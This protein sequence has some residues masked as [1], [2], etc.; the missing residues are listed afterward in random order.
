MGIERRGKEGRWAERR[1]EIEEKM[2]RGEMKM[3]GLRW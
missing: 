3:D 1:D 2:R